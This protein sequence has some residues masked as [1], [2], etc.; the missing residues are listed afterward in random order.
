METIA[1]INVPVLTQVIPA[2]KIAFALDFKCNIFDVEQVGSSIGVPDTTYQVSIAVDN[3]ALANNQNISVRPF[4]DFN[5][6]FVIA[7]ESTTLTVRVTFDFSFLPAAAVTDIF[8]LTHL[9]GDMLL[10]NDM[11][12]PYTA[13]KKGSTL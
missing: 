2:G 9:R 3:A 5:P 7:D 13:L 4:D 8:F 12:V 11:P 10:P 1:G 6:I